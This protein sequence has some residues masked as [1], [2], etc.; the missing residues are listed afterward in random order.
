MLPSSATNQQPSSSRQPLAQGANFLPLVEVVSEHSE[1]CTNFAQVMVKTDSRKIRDTNLGPKKK[2][3]KMQ[4][5]GQGVCLGCCSGNKHLSLRQE[6]ESMKRE[7]SELRGA[8]HSNSLALGQND[9][10]DDDARPVEAKSSLGDTKSTQPEVEQSGIKQHIGDVVL[11]NVG[12]QHFACLRSTLCRYGSPL[13][14]HYKLC[15]T[16]SP[17]FHL[18]FQ[19]GLKEHFWRRWRV[20]ASQQRK[21]T[22]WAASLLTGQLPHQS[23]VCT[24]ITTWLGQC[25]EKSG[26]PWKGY[27]PL[28]NLSNNYNNNNRDPIH[29]GK[30]LNFLR[31]GHPILPFTCS[32][33]QSCKRKGFLMAAGSSSS[34]AASASSSSPDGQ[35]STPTVQGPQGHLHSSDDFIKTVSLVKELDYYGLLNF[36]LPRQVEKDLNQWVQDFGSVFTL[37]RYHHQVA[38]LWIDHADLTESEKAGRADLRAH[39][40][41]HTHTHHWRAFISSL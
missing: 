4:Q 35:G 33:P 34:S 20:G 15:A 36:V 28:Y 40:H 41:T 1:A 37:Q 26:C 22:L 7:I 13:V 12:G 31:D 24:N 29:F 21:R 19:T 23:C 2:K 6:I 3:A 14:I 18:C 11:L 10:D 39:T 9:D 27:H 8:L 38:K 17:Y 25:G 16:S 5:N 32:F 30:I